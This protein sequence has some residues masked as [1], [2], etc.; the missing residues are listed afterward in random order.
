MSSSR[1]AAA[2]A[3][4]CGIGWTRASASA[5]ADGRE[6]YAYGGDFG[7]TR[8][9]GNFCINGMVW[10]DREPHPC[11]WEYK[12]VL[13]PVQVAPVTRPPGVLE[14]EN[15]YDFSG[16]QPPGHPWTLTAD[17]RVLQQGTA[18]IAGRLPAAQAVVCAS[19]CAQPAA[20]PGVEYWL[21]LSFTLAAEHPL[22]RGRA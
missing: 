5:R 9:D 18:A 10:P 3:A 16:P 21:T 15:S 4:S 17:G 2:S 7:E 6:Y 14:I 20:Q 19:P 1:T 22:G 11:L 8:H 12:K 13:Q